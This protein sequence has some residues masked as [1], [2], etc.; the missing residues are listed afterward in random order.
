MAT[1]YTQDSYQMKQIEEFLS[2][3]EDRAIVAEHLLNRREWRW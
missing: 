1:S 2:W 3:C